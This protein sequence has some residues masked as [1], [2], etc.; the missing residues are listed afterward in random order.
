LIVS[1]EAKLVRLI[2]GQAERQYNLFSALA[3]FRWIGIML[4]IGNYYILLANLMP[5]LMLR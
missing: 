1:E 3:V 4:G 2:V 5:W